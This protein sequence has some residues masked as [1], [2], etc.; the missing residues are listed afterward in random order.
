MCPACRP[1]QGLVA[2][3][4]QLE[5]RRV[6]EGFLGCPNCEARYPIREGVVRFED[7]G[8]S[9]GAG[10]PPGDPSETATVVAALMGLEKNGS[11]YVLLGHGLA[12]VAGLVA[13]LAEGVEVVALARAGEAPG[14]ARAP[15]PGVDVPGSGADAK[16]PGADAPG[17]GAEGPEEEQGGGRASLLEGCDPDRL[18]L[19]SGRFRGV[20]LTGGTGPAVEEA[21]RLLGPRGRL[22]V[23]APS[24]EARRAAAE[25]PLEVVASDARA[26]VAVRS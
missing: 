20:A 23:L 7:E 26:L 5:G 8:A 3:V 6:V 19:F 24:E 18:P 2:R 10:E 1:G 13:S 14:R 25:G 4:D 9:P 16:G 12:R 17:P 21:A 15:G 22:V 11:G